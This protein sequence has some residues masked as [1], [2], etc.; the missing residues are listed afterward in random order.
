[1]M[2]Y[3]EIRGMQ[4]RVLPYSLK[5][6]KQQAKGEASAEERASY[7]FVKGFSKTRWQ[8]SDLFKA[9]EPFGNILSAKVSLDRNHCSRGFG[10]I[11]YET[12]EQAASAISG[13]HGSVCSGETLTVTV[14]CPPERKQPV[15][16]GA[17]ASMVSAA[18]SASFTNLY[19][20]SFPREDFEDDDLKVSSFA[21][22]LSSGT[23]L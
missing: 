17:G 22:N 9:F 8:H 11:Q 10:Y 1:M 21:S 7:V 3:P 4:C 15:T 2:R 13:M 12:K 20:K 5:F 23:F 14:Y 18:Q 16:A 19:V 6:T